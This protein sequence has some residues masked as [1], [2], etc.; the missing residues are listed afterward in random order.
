MEFVSDMSDVCLHYI[1]ALS[2]L[3]MGQKFSSHN[4]HI[5]RYH[6]ELKKR[7]KPNCRLDDLMGML[8]E[9]LVPSY[10][11]KEVLR[12]THAR[13]L[14]MSVAQKHFLEYHPKNDD[15]MDQYDIIGLTDAKYKFTKRSSGTSHIVDVVGASSMPCLIKE[16]KIKCEHCENRSPLLKS[17][18]VCAHRMVCTCQPNM[19]SNMCKHQHFLALMM[20]KEVHRIL[21]DPLLDL[22]DSEEVEESH[23]SDPCPASSALSALEDPCPAS[24][25]L[26]AHENPCPAPNLLFDPNVH[27]EQVEMTD[28]EKWLEKLAEIQQGCK[29]MREAISDI[30]DSVTPEMGEWIDKWHQF[31]QE[32]P[33]PT[34]DMFKRNK[35]RVFTK[36]SKTYYPQAAEKKKRGRKHTKKDDKVESGILWKK[37]IAEAPIDNEN[38]RQWVDLLTIT[39]DKVDS[40]AKD[41]FSGDDLQNFHDAYKKAK[42]AWK[43]AGCDDYDSKRMHSGFIHC[44]VCAEQQIFLHFLFPG[45]V[46]VSR[47]LTDCTNLE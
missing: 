5:E 23:P 14:K 36:Q 8:E 41:L 35:N 29:K 13:G 10:L 27:E 26:S 42:L 32:N 25:A 11:N 34:R 12:K 38:S 21:M 47:G 30:P 44:W 31:L 1:C 18:L 19:Y 22:I 15:F 20:P 17:V 45:Y 39:K 4:L 46:V 9:D 37:A 43:C 24:S 33:P 6:W 7:L 40:I 28:Q 3:D 16:C 2:K